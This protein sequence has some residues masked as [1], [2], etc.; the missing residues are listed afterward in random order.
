MKGLDRSERFTWREA[1]RRLTMCEVR[2]SCLELW[3]LALAHV[4]RLGCVLRTGA[5]FRCRAGVT[6]H[7]GMH[8]LRAIVTRKDR[9]V[10]G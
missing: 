1:E 8:G 7:H 9:R 10:E 5:P 3:E 6:I 4:P 2:W